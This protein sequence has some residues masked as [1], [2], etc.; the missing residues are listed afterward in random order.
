MLLP[1]GSPGWKSTFPPWLVFTM[2][3]TP[4]APFPIPATTNISSGK[5][6]FKLEH[7]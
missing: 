5:S 6:K 4:V 3:V 7:G 1:I 2:G